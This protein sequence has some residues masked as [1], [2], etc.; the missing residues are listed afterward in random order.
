MPI[1]RGEIVI[2]LLLRDRSL[3]HAESAKG[4]GGHKLVCTARVSAR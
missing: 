3:W 2:Q 4:T 1:F